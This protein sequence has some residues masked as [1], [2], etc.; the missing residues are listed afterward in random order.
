MLMSSITLAIY[1]AH[2]RMNMTRNMEATKAVSSQAAKSL[3]SKVM[4]RVKEKAP[5]VRVNRS[6][7]P[8]ARY[9]LSST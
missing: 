5:A 9:H 7:K 8:S 6:R 2:Q 3:V 4:E 1:K